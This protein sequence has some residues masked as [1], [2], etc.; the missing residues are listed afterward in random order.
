M[1]FCS[2]ISSLFFVSFDI[3]FLPT[4]SHL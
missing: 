3:L 1:H 4:M 2:S